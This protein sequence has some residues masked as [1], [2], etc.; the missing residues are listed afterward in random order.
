MTHTSNEPTNCSKKRWNTQQLQKKIQSGVERVTNWARSGGKRAS[1]SLH[2]CRS[3]CNSPDGAA[4]WTS[5][6][7]PPQCLLLAQLGPS[8]TPVSPRHG[9]TP[10]SLS[11]PR[12]L[13]L[14]SVNPIHSRHEY[15]LL[16]RST[17]PPSKYSTA[18]W[19][20]FY[21]YLYLPQVSQKLSYRQYLFFATWGL[22]SEFF[23]EA[24]A[25]MSPIPHVSGR[26]SA[27]DLASWVPVWWW[28]LVFPNH[29][30][31]LSTGP[32]MSFRD[33]SEISEQ[34]YRIRQWELVER[35][36]IRSCN[37]CIDY[38]A[39]YLRLGISDV[40]PENSS[41]HSILI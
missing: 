3:V 31:D 23:S 37:L 12:T 5:I 22:S 1:R 26:R 28:L 30:R 34:N 6:Q 16:P 29:L 15:H 36:T 11:P 18:L 9:Q 4:C 25:P 17:T 27:F 14:I 20:S 38:S 13:M 33:L 8:M 40:V 19:N 35:A 10:S 2:H 7:R 24:V 41:L 32:R 21:T 39:Y